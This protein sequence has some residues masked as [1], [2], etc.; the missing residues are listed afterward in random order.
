MRTSLSTYF[1]IL[2]SL[3]HTFDI[4]HTFSC[5]AKQNKIVNV[6]S[7]L[8]L[9]SDFQI[10]Y[11]LSA[12]GL[13]RRPTMHCIYYIDTSQMPKSLHHQPP[14]PLRR[15][16]GEAF[17]CLDIPIPN[18][19][20]GKALNG[21]ILS[22]FL[23]LPMDLQLTSVSRLASIYSCGRSICPPCSFPICSYIPT[24]FGKVI[25]HTQQM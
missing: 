1:H 21:T 15:I 12:C 2:H 8:R 19:G 17:H 23:L 14:R 18:A 20:L 25:K 16:M 3:A 5:F 7:K 13:D 24:P 6:K 4:T 11:L 10:H 22:F 9:T